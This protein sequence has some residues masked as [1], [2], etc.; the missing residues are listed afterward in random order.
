MKIETSITFNLTDGF[1]SYVDL[2]QISNGIDLKESRT[3]LWGPYLDIPSGSWKVTFNGMFEAGNKES[4]C[5]VCAENGLV[6]AGTSA[7]HPGTGKIAEIEFSN[8][9][10]NT[11]VEFRV[12]PAIGSRIRIDSI[13]LQRQ[14][15][16]TDTT[17]L[18]T[19]PNT[20]RSFA[21]YQREG[22]NLLLDEESLVDRDI[23]HNG[24]WEKEQLRYIKELASGCRDDKAKKIFLDIGS[25][26]GLYSLHMSRL[27]VF[28]Q[29]IAFE[30][31]EL[32]YRHLQ[33]NLL[34]NDPTFLIKTHNFAVSE[35]DGE[36]Y[37]FPSWDHPL[38]NRGGVGLIPEDRDQVNRVKVSTRALDGFLSLE[39]NIIF[40][41]IDVE[42]AEFSVL[43]GMRKILRDN[44]CVLQ[45]EALVFNSDDVEKHAQ[46]DATLVELGYR[47]IHSIGPDNYYS[48][49]H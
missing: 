42:G 11:G 10:M 48:N 8:P 49:F 27:K 21:I 2:S 23:I 45:L 16:Y 36:A 13:I 17:P 46:T 19:I 32:N 12:F 47:R 44:R 29:I 35:E 43:R 34:L 38:K 15:D 6:V 20:G 18:A 9:V 37:F 31:D 26:F 30:A 28:D 14:A 24:V 41:K 39:G 3:L 25:Y 4:T 22:M 40:A 1:Q 33:A 5:D 7:I